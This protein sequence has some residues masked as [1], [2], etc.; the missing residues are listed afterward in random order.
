MVAWQI[1]H[2]SLLL[3]KDFFWVVNMMMHWCILK[4]MDKRIP[5]SFAYI[6]HFIKFNKE[7]ENDP[8]LLKIIQK[9]VLNM[10]E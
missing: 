2:H 9:F 7:S 5:A 1:A 3:S 6:F 4:K 8:S 10:K